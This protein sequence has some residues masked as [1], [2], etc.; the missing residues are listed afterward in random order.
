MPGALFHRSCSQRRPTTTTSTTNG[1]GCPWPRHPSRSGFSAASASLSG[2]NSAGPAATAHRGRDG[3]AVQA[4]NARAGLAGDERARG[5]VPVVQ[6]ALV[7]AVEPSRGDRAQVDGGHAGPPDVPHPRQQRGDDLALDLAPGRLVA[8]PGADERLAE[9]HAWTAVQPS[10]A[11]E[12]LRCDIPDSESSQAPPPAYRAEQLAA[13]R[14]VHRRRATIF[15]PTS[16]PT[17]PPVTRRP[18]P[19]RPRRRSTPPSRAARTGS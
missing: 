19:R 2:P 15:L 10:R 16:P 13:H 6:A 7:V 17:S 3:R 12:P 14:D 18:P 5:P 11:G 9:R 1:C 8:E 4:A